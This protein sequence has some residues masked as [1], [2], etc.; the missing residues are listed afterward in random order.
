MGHA[1]AAVRALQS[2]LL[3]TAGGK[4]FRRLG[5]RVVRM[6]ARAPNKSDVSP[7]AVTEKECD[8][9]MDDVDAA[10]VRA[11]GECGASIAGPL[12]AAPRI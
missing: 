7:Q 3:P 8:I 11:V 9:C 4:G 10:F 12:P 2:S 5:F 1:T 6:G